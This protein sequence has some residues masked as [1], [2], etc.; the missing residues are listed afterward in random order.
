M[1]AAGTSMLSVDGQNAASVEVG[2]GGC[3]AGRLMCLGRERFLIEVDWRDFV[4]NYGNALV[5]PVGAD[6][7]G[8][9]FF[10]DADNWE[11]LVKVLN[12]CAITDH[13]WLFSAATTNVE[14]TLRVTDT[15]SGLTKSYFNALGAAAAAV[16]DTTALAACD[17]MG[18]EAEPEEPPAT[19]SLLA[20][21]RSLVEHPVFAEAAARDPR[22]QGD[23]TP[24]ST[25]LCL[26]NGRFRIEVEWKD[27][28]G[29]TGA[30]E[31]VPFG[32]ADSGLFFF[33]DEDNWEMLVKVLNGCGF[34]GHYWVFAAATTDVEY[35]LR[36]TDT[37]MGDFKEYFN[38]LGTAAPAIT[39]TSALESCP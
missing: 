26:N 25:N 35:T 18:L 23:C 11:I 8:L 15:V 39:D 7:S 32:T 20:E 9:Y 27:F 12:G 30:G 31:V 19:A 33:F 10:F 28:V 36:A 16:T 17:A 38:P 5:A 21:L 24:S 14:Y 13:F 37:E 1:A 34:N 2:E 22:K 6:D 4:G 29:N 3:S